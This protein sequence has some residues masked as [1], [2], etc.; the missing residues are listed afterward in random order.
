MLTVAD[1]CSSSQCEHS[2]NNIKEAYDKIRQLFEDQN[3]D[4]SHSDNLNYVPGSLTGVKIDHCKPGF[5]KNISTIDNNTACQGCCVTCPPGR[6]SAKHDTVCVPCAAG[7][8]NDKYGQAACE[9]CPKAQS[10]D[11]EGAQMERNCHRI[12]PMWMAFSISSASTSLLLVTIWV[13]S[14]QCC[15]RTAA[16]QY[17]GE[18]ESGLKKR[19]QNFANIASDADIQEQRNKLSPIKLQRKNQPKY[20]VD[21]LEEESVGLLSNDDVTEPSTSAGVSP[22]PEVTGPSELESSFEDQSPDT[23][24]KDFSPNDLP[25]NQQKFASIMKEKRP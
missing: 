3:I 23:L 25:P 4:S 6:F 22:S 21:F 9:N 10:S 11:G 8:Y 7:S 24:Q 5:G 19:V 2:I 13:V 18:A 16:A 20:K 1:L 15:K 14:T 17:V 12:L